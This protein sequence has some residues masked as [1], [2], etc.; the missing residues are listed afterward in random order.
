MNGV[1]R[2]GL[3]L[4]ALAVVVAGCGGG[5]GNSKAAYRSD[6]AKISKEAG[7]AHQR[8]E[9]GAPQAATVAQV[10][11]LL[12]RFAADEDRIGNEVS[13]LKPPKDAAAANAELARGQ[14]DDAN[15]IRAILPKL[16]KYKSV[17]QAFG[18]LQTV[19]N[20]KGGREGDEAVAKLKKLG[21]TSGS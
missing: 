14:H 7:T 9:Q 11:A 2:C 5:S 21:Y 17:Q 8:I 13:K 3:V 6:L 16:A 15:E 19:G 18:F 10:Q 4:C 12:R 20:T 1:R